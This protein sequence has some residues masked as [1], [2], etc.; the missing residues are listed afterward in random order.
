M[1]ESY[2][3]DAQRGLVVCRAWGDLSSEDLHNHYRRLVADPA[4]SPHYEQLAD[5]TEVTQFTVDSETIES[6]ARA[7]ASS[8]RG[9]VERWWRRRA[10]PMAW[11]GC[12]RRMARHPVRRC[13]C[14]RR[15]APPRR[16]WVWS[17]EADVRRA[18]V[19]AGRR[20]P[21]ADYR[22]GGSNSKMVSRVSASACGASV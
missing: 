11:R 15:W 6:E 21:L 14:S 7:R 12:S 1:P 22:S 8:R 16:G 13:R 5:L 10:W 2:E 20:S 3:I 9:H 4:F 18:F 19:V 17:R